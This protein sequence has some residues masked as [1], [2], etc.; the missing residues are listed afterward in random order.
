MSSR[1]HRRCLAVGRTAAQRFHQHLRTITKPATGSLCAS[2]LADLVC[3]K[4]GFIA[5]NALLRQQLIVLRRSVKPLLR[6]RADWAVLVLIAGRVR[7]GRQSQLIVQ[8][9]MLPRWHRDLF[10]RFRRRTYQATVLGVLRHDARRP[11]LCR[12]ITEKQEAPD[13]T[14]SF[15]LTR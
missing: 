14:D 11:G 12:A 9:D 13:P 5:E 15:G 3:S 2:A 6:T 4:P 1:S 8:P 10:R 7:T